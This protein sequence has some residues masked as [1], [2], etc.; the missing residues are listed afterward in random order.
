MESDRRLSLFGLDALLEKNHTMSSNVKI[1]S[2]QQKQI[3][4]IHYL[5]RP[6]QYRS[7]QCRHIRWLFPVFIALP[8]YYT[9]SLV[10]FLIRG[11][12]CVAFAQRMEKHCCRGPNDGPLSP[13]S[14]RR[15][16]KQTSSA[17]ILPYFLALSFSFSP[18]LACQKRNNVKA[19][20]GHPL[21]ISRN[22]PFSS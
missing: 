8:I 15:R 16:P 19:E 21:P 11:L 4:K 18:F 5:P 17:T 14:G 10:R 12:Q 9:D 6:Q 1:H 13:S 22:A 3:G 7:E 20:T 2:I